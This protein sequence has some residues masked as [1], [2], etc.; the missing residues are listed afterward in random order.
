EAIN[1][2]DKRNT[3]FDAGN[4]LTLSA[5]PEPL[6]FLPAAGFRDRDTGKVS[7]NESQSNYYWTSTVSD[8]TL[9]SSMY[10]DHS[11]I[12]SGSG[13]ARAHGASVRCVKELPN[14][15]TVDYENYEDGGD[16]Y[17]TTYPGLI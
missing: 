3:V 16:L 12:Y 8:N 6:M 1:T 13:S 4:D 9:S 15:I 14:S 17:D 10:F 7:Q 2:Q 11:R 5:A